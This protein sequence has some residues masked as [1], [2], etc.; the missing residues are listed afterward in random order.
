MWIYLCKT[1]FGKISQVSTFL[2]FVRCLSTWTWIFA[3]DLCLWLWSGLCVKFGRQ[4]FLM[5]MIFWSDWDFR[6]WSNF[7]LE[8]SF[9]ASSAL[10]SL[11]VRW[12]RWYAYFQV[13]LRI[14][15]AIIKEIKVFIW[16]GALSFPLSFS[17]CCYIP[18][19]IEVCSKCLKTIIPVVLFRDI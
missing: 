2:L 17:H 8:I 18:P 3:E 14:L 6:R 4:K 1:G 7:E 9:E 19:D 13:C 11:F 15:W 5:N 16:I 10:L 12:T